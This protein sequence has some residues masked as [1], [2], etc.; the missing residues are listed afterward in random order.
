MASSPEV[1]AACGLPSIE[2]SIELSQ[3]VSWWD[4]FQAVTPE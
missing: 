2:L 4:L 3:Y 1:F